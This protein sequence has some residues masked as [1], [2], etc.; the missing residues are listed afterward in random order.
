MP[1][2]K[3]SPPK[4]LRKH[5]ENDDEHH[6]LLDVKKCGAHSTALTP[7]FH[8]NV[9]RVLA[10]LTILASATIGASAASAQTT[11]PANEDCQTCH[12]EPSMARADGRPVVVP[13]QTFADSIH[14]VLSCTDCH[15]DLAKATEFP[16]TADLMSVNCAS[17]HEEPS[18]GF[19][20]S[21][22]ATRAATATGAVNCM[23]CHGPPHEI[24][25]ASDPASATNKLNVA[26]TCAQCHG[27]TVKR[28]APRGPS[29]A[30]MFTDSIHGMALQRTTVAP[31]CTDCHRS[32][33]I[34]PRTDAE[35]PVHQ[36]NVPTTCGTCHMDQRRLFDESVHAEAVK[37]G[38][39]NAPV[40]SSCHTA[41]S[42]RATGSGEYLLGAVEECGTCHR[43]ALETYRDGFHGKVTALGFTAVAKCADC[44]QPH[45][46]HGP[47]D[48]RS[49]V[50]P[51]NLVTTCQSCHA[52]ANANFVKYQPHANK[53]DRERLPQLYYAGLFMEALLAGVFG[54]FGLHTLLWFLRE[55]TGSADTDG[56]RA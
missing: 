43:E 20:R 6:V 30:D 54:F 25:P 51:A 55:R 23:S 48:P 47:S 44:H 8:T 41:H 38:N 12:A 3:K 13:P 7:S 42:I 34:L 16:H 29:V 4:I 28:G 5:Q 49:S 45:Q 17:C 40:C 33:D 1:S 10:F 35:S 36:P 37:Q 24:K 50:A 18:T 46:I 19:T 52:A 15:T 32:H 2:A 21:A 53:D 11:G 31:T 27:E 14:G 39:A 26:T 56:R 22:H 9:R